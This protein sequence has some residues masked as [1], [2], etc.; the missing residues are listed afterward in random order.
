MN[1]LDRIVGNLL[2]YHKIDPELM[3]AYRSAIPSTVNLRIVVRGDSYVATIKSVDNEKLPEDVLLITEA[4][5]E[6]ALVDMINDLI[7]SYKKIPETYRRYYK[8]V[9]KPQGSVANAK[10]LR[11]VKAA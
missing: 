10:D 4:Q 3:E 2:G 6:A 9:L 7:F 8:R 1:W 11:L 5:S